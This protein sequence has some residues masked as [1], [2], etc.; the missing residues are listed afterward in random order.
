[1]L[2]KMY[3]NKENGYICK[4]TFVIFII[5]IVNF[6]FSQSREKYAVFVPAEFISKDF[7]EQATF[8]LPNNGRYIKDYGFDLYFNYP[9]SIE[10]I[11]QK[12]EA[13]SIPV[14][15]VVKIGKEN[16][17]IFEKVG[18][19]DCDLAELL[20]SNSSL[21]G[22]SSGGGVQ[23]LTAANRGCLSTEHQSSWYYLN[24]QTGGSLTMMIDPASN[25]DDYDFAIWGPFTAATAGV[26]CPPVSAPIRCSFSSLDDRTGLQSMNLGT[27][28][29]CGFLGWFPCPPSAVGDVTEGAGGD[30]FVLPLNVL[31]NQVYILLVDN[32]STS[33][34]PYSMSFGGSAVLGCTPVVLSVDLI[35]FT[36]KNIKGFNTL[37]WETNSEKNNDYFNI[38]WSSDL[39]KGV[40][41]NVSRIDACGDCPMK[42][43]FSHAEYTE[44]TINYYRLKQTDKDGFYKYYDPIAIDNTRSS[45]QILKVMNIL[46]QEVDENYPGLKVILYS[47]GTTLKKY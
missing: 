17:S 47:D 44:G 41:E 14:N 6:S 15:N 19:T 43:N 1:M 30:S 11:K 33:S 3:S 29:G 45:K 22:N 34:N 35:S 12:F 20:C 28:S 38:E 16:F 10:S 25:S 9:Q 42:Y 21:A 13:A 32:F 37:S 4:S 39:N 36:G 26:N 40:W 46:G 27:P 18:G 8:D 2:L 24:V 5:F 7:L 31:A 23:E